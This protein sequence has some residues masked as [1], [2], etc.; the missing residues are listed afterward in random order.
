GCKGSW[1][2]G[3]SPTSGFLENATKGPFAQL[4]QNLSGNIL[5]DGLFMMG[6]M[7]IGLAL[8]TGIGVRVAVTTGSLLMFMM[9]ASALPPSTNP[10]LDEHIVYILV[11][12][13]IGFAN[14]YQKWGLGRWWSGTSLVRR[15]P[16][17]Q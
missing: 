11:L 12:L 2:N 9:W 4:F 13:T 17:L 5:I 1:L 8:I 15:Y 6:L 7:L 10:L 16:F 14:K 3:G